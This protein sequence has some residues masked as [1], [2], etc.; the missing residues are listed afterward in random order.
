MGI[1]YNTLQKRIQEGK[2]KAVNGRNTGAELLRYLAK[3]KTI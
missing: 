2:I 1:S 3:K